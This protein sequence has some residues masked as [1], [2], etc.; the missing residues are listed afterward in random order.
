MPT[1]NAPR[2]GP[3]A[4]LVV[5]AGVCGVFFMGL[6][7]MRLAPG[8]ASSDAAS[9]AATSLAER[10]AAPAPLLSNGSGEGG[11][12]PLPRALVERA[13]ERGVLRID[14]IIRADGL[15]FLAAGSAVCRDG[16]HRWVGRAMG[17]APGS[18]DDSALRRCLLSIGQDLRGRMPVAV[19]SR[20]GTSVPLTFRDALVA[21]L[22]TLGLPEV[23]I[24]AR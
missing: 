12:M 11:Y 4:T 9:G 14:V 22:R 16:A 8:P 21:N 5:A 18:Y 6:R 15:D 3:V 24:D 20:A 2:P 10:D 17:D 13:A 1:T 7:S 19:V 23:L